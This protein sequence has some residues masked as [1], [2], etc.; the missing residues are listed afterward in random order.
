MGDP[1]IEKANKKLREISVLSKAQDLAR[2]REMA[3]INRKIE[4][5]AYYE[6]GL[7]KGRAE[8]RAEGQAEGESIG[9][10]KSIL[11]FLSARNII[12]P[13]EVRNTILACKDPVQL[14]DWLTRAASVESVDELF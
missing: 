3:R 7:E 4:A 2:Q 10:A 6:E 12:V 9:I 1:M 14:D 8:G 13:D 5:S 11:S